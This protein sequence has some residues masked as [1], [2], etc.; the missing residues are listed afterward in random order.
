MEH[1]LNDFVMMGPPNSDACRVNL[2]QILSICSELG[3]PLAMKKLEGPSQ[4]LTFLGMEI[5]TIHIQ[6]PLPAGKLSLLQ[7]LLAQWASMLPTG[8]PGGH[9][10]ARLSGCEARQSSH[11][12]HHQPPLHPECNQG[13]PPT[14]G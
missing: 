7:S 5:D 4:C 1:Y 6:L 11:T 14:S 3:V 9:L 8:V 12:T 13:T 10:T 2:D